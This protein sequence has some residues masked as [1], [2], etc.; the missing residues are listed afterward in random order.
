MRRAGHV[1]FRKL[2][3][4]TE[5]LVAEMS[6]QDV[7]LS[8]IAER[9]Q[10]PTA[11]IYHFFPTREAAL[12]A[13][14]A[15]HHDILQRIAREELRPPP[16]TWQELVRRKVVQSTTHY[17]EHPAALRLFLSAGITVELRTADITQTMV[18]AEIRANLLNHYFDMPPVRDWVR[19]LA[20][21]IAIVDGICILSYSQFG[22]L[23]PEFMEDAHSAS[24]AY[25][26]TFLPERIERR[27][28]PETPKHA[29]LQ[30]PKEKIA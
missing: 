18:L 6:I 9:A 11:S 27:Q 23:T 8:Q 2:L 7:G 16:Q 30:D 20:T 12:L 17:N 5:S 24:V 15:E 1:R 29:V 25:L 14:A 19:R 3:D 26:R 13:L 22:Y 4:A 10:V 21:S 28:T